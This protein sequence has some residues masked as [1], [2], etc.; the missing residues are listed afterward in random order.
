MA[1]EYVFRGA[2]SVKSDV[3]SFGVLLLEILTGQKNSNYCESQSM[4][5]LLNH[6]INLELILVK[7]NPQIL[8]INNSE[9]KYEKNNT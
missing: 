3:L 6:A 8:E 9:H 4:E 5:V 1:P 7:K 2:L